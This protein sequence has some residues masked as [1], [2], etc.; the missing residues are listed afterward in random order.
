MKTIRLSLLASCFV[1][2]LSTPAAWGV[3]TFGSFGNDTMHGT[4]GADCLDGNPG[5]DLIFGYAGND[6]LNGYMGNDRIYGM[7]DNDTISGCACLGVNPTVD[8]DTLSGGNGDDWLSGDDRFDYLDGGAGT[9]T[10][11]GEVEV[12]CEL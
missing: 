4:A 6:S 1:A 11:Y 9:D 2:L 10:C 8:D 7:D 12:D 5:D 3:C